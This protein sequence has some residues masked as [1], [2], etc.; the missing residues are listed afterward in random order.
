MRRNIEYWKLPGTLVLAN[1]QLLN[2][3]SELYSN[4]YGVWGCEGKFPGKHIKLSSNRIR[5]WLDSECA[6]LYCAETDEVIIGYAIAFS[7]DLKG[8][9]GVVTWVTQLV[10]HSDYRKQGIAKNILFS[11]WGLS[12]HFAWGIVSANPY[13]VR[14]LEKATRRRAIPL[15][16]KKNSTKL[17]NLGRGYV[18]FIDDNTTIE[19]KENTSKINT[20][21]F[22]DHKNIP[23]MLSNVISE[24]IPWRLGSIEE[25][26]EWF[27]FTFRDQEPISLT[28]EEIENMIITS[29][30]VVMQAYSRMNLDSTYQTWMKNTE[31]E[32]DFILEK[33]NIKKGELIYD[34]GC[35]TGRHSISL[36]QRGYKVIGIDYLIENID[37]AQK[38]VEKFSVNNIDFKVFDCRNYENSQKAKLV[39]CLY[40]VIGSFS[41]EQENIKIIKTAYDLLQNNGFAIFTVMNYEATLKRA[42]HKF[43]LE[44]DANILINLL[45]SPNMQNT[46]EVFN[47]DYY[48]VDTDTQLVYR[49][50]QFTIGKMLPQEMVVRDKRYRM[51]EIEE[52][53]L[54]VGFSVLEKKYTNASNWRKSFDAETK[55]AKEILL[56]CKKIL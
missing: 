32:I 16:I 37:K 51:S 35:G 8:D 7:K 49:R 13:A 23:R 52:I 55:E 19:V 45:A 3:C 22:V 6:T 56:I 31:L 10:V 39:L 29:D 12:T 20:K 21:F 25:G 17:L 40:D 46:G 43:S 4:H 41:D 47:P 42:K 50:E 2:K 54:S 1:E 38:K 5:T 48:A 53:C 11:I 34:L 30:T 44:E 33:I 28:K 24:D 27:A 14:A 9:Y 36:A 18:P 15:R 26:W